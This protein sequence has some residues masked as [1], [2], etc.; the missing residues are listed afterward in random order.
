MPNRC[1]GG[2]VSV[3]GLLTGSDLLAALRGHDL[4]EA[5]ILPAATLNADGI[6]LDN[7]TPD[8]LARELGVPLYFC[9]GPREV[10]EALGLSGNTS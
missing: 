5:L 1:Y 2:G 7:L 8:D 4:G 9:R 10:V 3:A 6:F